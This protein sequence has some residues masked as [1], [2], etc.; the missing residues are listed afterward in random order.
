MLL[1]RHQICSCLYLSVSGRSRTLLQL[2][3]CLPDVFQFGLAGR[4]R[5]V[6]T[7]HRRGD[8][9]CMQ[10]FRVAFSDAGNVF[11]GLDKRIEHFLGLGLGWLDH[12][13]FREDLTGGEKIPLDN[14]FE[15]AEQKPRKRIPAEKKLA[16]KRGV[17]QDFLAFMHGE[18][19][20]IINLADVE[21][22]HA[23]AYI[24][25][26]RRAGK[27]NKAV[28]YS[29][30][31]GKKKHKQTI[32]FEVKGNESLSPR[33]INFYQVTCAE[34]FTLLKDDAGLQSNPFSSIPKMDVK[35]E[36]RDAFTPEEL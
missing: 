11:H 5:L 31:S 35:E 21:K 15:L 7:A 19:P 8:G 1:S 18:Y 6:E 13:G 33:T 10:G 23:E 28:E 29:R 14:A 24:S 2:R 12:D 36:T 22:K 20:D 27:Y 25:Q 32:S 17:W 26:L 3:R 34:V 30:A 16:L 4:E 9:R